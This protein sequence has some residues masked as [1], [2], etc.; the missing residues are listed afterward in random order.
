[1]HIRDT[2][3]LIATITVFFLIF[4]MFS[5][6]NYLKSSSDLTAKKVLS[7]SSKV[8]NLILHGYLK[9]PESEWDSNFSSE[10]LR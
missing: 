3:S 8:C 1:M 5:E 9:E 2:A 6:H 7:D 4:L 10:V